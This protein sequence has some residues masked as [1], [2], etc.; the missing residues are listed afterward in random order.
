MFVA[1]VIL[2]SKVLA[3]AASTSLFWLPFSRPV[4]WAC[5]LETQSGGVDVMFGPI[6]VE[7]PLM[8]WYSIGFDMR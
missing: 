4:C 5:M 7:F 2:P 1:N 3:V 8:W 6:S